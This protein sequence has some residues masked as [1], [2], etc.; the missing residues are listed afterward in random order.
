MIVRRLALSALLLVA[1]SALAQDGDTPP[2]AETPPA[3]TPSAETPPAETDPAKADPAKTDEAPD[4]ADPDKPDPDK[5]APEPYEPYAGTATALAEAHVHVGLAT[6]A[7]SAGGR[8]FELLT[9]TN[10]DAA[11]PPEWIAFVIAGL[12]GRR[13]ADE[14][15]LAVAVAGWLADQAEELPPEVAVQV[16][17]DANPDARAARHP[18][19]GNDTRVDDD[20]DGEWNE[21]GPDD[22]NGDEHLGWMRYP[23]PTGQLSVA[24]DEAETSAPVWAEPTKGKP[25]THRLVPEGRDIDDDGLWNEDGP[26]GVDLSRNFTWRFEE[27]VPAT[28]RWPASEVA[29]KRLMDHLVADERIALVLEIGGADTSVKNPGSNE[30]WPKLPDDD[31]ALLDTLRSLLD[32]TKR[33]DALKGR[34]H[35]PGPGSLGSTVVHQF[36]RMWIGRAPLGRS[37]A[38]WPDADAIWPEHL[39]IRWTPVEGA[40]L[41]PGA[42]VASIVPAVLEAE[43]E[44][45]PVPSAASEGHD[46]AAFLLAAAKARADVSFTGTAATGSSGVLRLRTKIVNTGRLPTHTA[47]GAAVRGRRPLNV[48]VVL[49]RGAKLLAGKPH[50]QIERLGPGAAS[51]ELAWVISGA[52]GGSVRIEVSGPDTGT[53]VLVEQIP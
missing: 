20:Q 34:P 8:P 50:V 12:H 48:H 7:T 53:D 2:P 30:A 21:D 23:D 4:E 43:D 47:R 27:H 9:I 42:E 51:G 35:A 46:L 25:R 19:A 6:V 26:G 45:L 31:N 17:A 40:G 28:G 38:V 41:P 36:G 22:V 24:A 52:S 5:P 32:E 10:P 15:E 11:E 3:E 37:G 16:L 18:R 13:P 49:P 29:T 44:P 33:A 1:S 14:S 39:A